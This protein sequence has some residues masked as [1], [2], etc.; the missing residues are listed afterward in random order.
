MLDS[1]RHRAIVR[2]V[3]ELAHNLGFEVV[4][5]GVESEAAANTLEALNC[6]VAQGYLYGQPMSAR[7]VAAWL[8]AGVRHQRAA[9]NVS[10]EPAPTN[11]LA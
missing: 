10:A 2:S 7:A 6:D 11:L 4:A 9:D 5:E 8:R 1:P 3:I